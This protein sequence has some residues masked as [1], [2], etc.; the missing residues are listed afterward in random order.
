[1]NKPILLALFCLGVAMLLSDA[2]QFSISVFPTSIRASLYDYM[3]GSY[4]DTPVVVQAP[5]SGSDIYMVY[6]YRT[7]PTDKRRFRL[8]RIGLSGNLEL[9]NY[10]GTLNRDQGYPSLTM[11]TPTGMPLF[12]WH[13]VLGNNMDNY[14]DVAFTAGDASGIPNPMWEPAIAIDNPYTLNDFSS[15]QF[16]WPTVAIGPSPLEN[17]RRIYVLGRNSATYTTGVNGHNVLLAYRDVSTNDLY[18][19]DFLQNWN[20]VS[21]PQ[22]DD[23]FFFPNGYER[24]F[25]GTL[26]CREDGRIYL[27]GN[28]SEQYQEQVADTQRKLTVFVNDNYGQGN[29]RQISVPSV[30]IPSQVSNAPAGWD[31]A[32]MRFDLHT[33]NHF[34][35]VWDNELRIHYPQLFTA[36]DANGNFYDSF[37][38]IRDVIF[39]TV[40]E[41]FAIH[42]LYPRGAS[43]N[44]DPCYTPWDVNEDNLVDDP[45][46]NLPLIFP[47]C[48][49]D[50]SAH[51]NAMTYYYNNVKI[52]KANSNGVMACVWS[53]SKA[54]VTNPELTGP[55]TYIAISPD[56]G[57]TWLDPIVLNPLQHPTPNGT[58]T[59]VYPA[60]ELVLL[61]PDQNENPVYRLFLMFFDDN[62]WGAAALSGSSFPMDGGN[63]S[64]MALDITVPLSASS[65]PEIPVA[66]LKINSWPNPF[67]E[68]CTLKVNGTAKAGQQ[69][70]IFNLKGQKVRRLDLNSDF[71]TRWDG[72]DE[73][74]QALAAGIYFARAHAGNNSIVHK[75]VISK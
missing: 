62:N 22:L 68:G 64:Y 72:R 39:D 10:Y 61:G 16:V 55:D 8:A 21:I 26:V 2:P 46:M 1:M 28:H 11:D 42:D 34:N 71:E 4:M 59:F 75:L 18:D 36:Y 5:E 9:D 44:S 14:L 3:P 13:E 47:F 67:S 24:Q 63:V 7:N 57:N 58:M 32:N 69:L 56:N 51:S 60:N 15:N 70:E 40:T 45:Q 41:S 38:S 6:H 19:G 54:A 31:L 29:W 30:Q 17:L 65:D 12:A 53:D 49:P 48:Y 33:S 25:D 50:P 43:P 23:W 27:I 52:T 74:G 20:A 66:N 37:F 73:S 35:A